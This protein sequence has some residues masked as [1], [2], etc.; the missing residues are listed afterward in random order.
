MNNS[1]ANLIGFINHNP[2]VVD[3]LRQRIARLEK[4]CETLRDTLR[5]ERA[6]ADK[7]KWNNRF[8]V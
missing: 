6:A 2:N 7:I 4:D 1:M 5:R 8:V 3:T